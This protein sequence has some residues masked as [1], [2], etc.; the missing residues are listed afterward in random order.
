M[1]LNENIISWQIDKVTVIFPMRFKDSTD[2][3][4]ATSFLQVQ[5]LVLCICDEYTFCL[6]KYIGCALSIHF[7][8]VYLVVELSCLL[9][10][11]VLVLLTLMMIF[12]F[13]TF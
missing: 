6:V 5:H 7:H 8:P 3:V 12:L 11:I 13:N 1:Q 4:L 2:T 10:A 9:L